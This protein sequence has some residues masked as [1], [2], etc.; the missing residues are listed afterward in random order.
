MSSLALKLNR[1]V[2]LQRPSSG[3]DA[4]GQ[5]ITNWQ[6]VVTIWAHIRNENG[7]QTIQA[8][9]EVSKVK[10]S[11]RI[12]YRTGVTEDMR[13]LYGAVVYRIEAILPDEEG[14]Q[15]MDLVCEVIK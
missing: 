7:A 3:K 12:R 4:V 10:S 9:A 15:F 2:T 8:G 13:V 1:R 11:V 14:K 6:D 5:P